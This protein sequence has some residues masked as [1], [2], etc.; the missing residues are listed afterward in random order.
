MG[1]LFINTLKGV[2]FNWFMKLSAS[3]IKKCA[4]L[5]KLFLAHFFEED[6][7]ISIPTLLTTKQKK[8]ESVKTFVERF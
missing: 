6:T 1:R 8:G 5:E 7:E 2:A 3:S 4:D